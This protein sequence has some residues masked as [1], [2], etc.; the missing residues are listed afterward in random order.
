MSITVHELD[1]ILAECAGERDSATPE[2][3]IDDVTFE[4]LGYDSLALLETLGR[5]Q[6]QLG[7]RLD[8]SLIIE[9]RTPA[10]LVA[11]VNNAVVGAGTSW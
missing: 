11:M 6:I 9:A 7:V 5:L 2:A 1:R 4:D 8:E 10:E 3:G